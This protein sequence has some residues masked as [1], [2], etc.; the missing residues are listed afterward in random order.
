MQSS[1]IGLALEKKLK[2]N[3]HAGRGHPFCTNGNERRDKQDLGGCESHWRQV[4]IEK[5]G[6]GGEA[7]QM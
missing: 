6:G 5:L 7:R 3:L 4:A 1:S 2:L